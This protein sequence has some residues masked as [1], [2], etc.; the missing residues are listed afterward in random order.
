MGDKFIR[1]I[2]DILE[3]FESLSG[4]DASLDLRDNQR[5]SGKSNR[6]KRLLR[7]SGVTAISPK[8]VMLG[9]I[10]VLLGAFVLNALIPGTVP[11][12][13]WAGL[14]LFVVAYGLLF[15]GSDFRY[16]KRWR[17]RLI[18]EEGTGS[19]FYRLRRWMR[20]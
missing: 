1:E 6:L 17:G 15:M 19:F 7:L 20:S 4:S 16:E 12:L 18:D 14:A 10:I 3:R 11:L 9:G 13:A 2:E 5:G 8:A